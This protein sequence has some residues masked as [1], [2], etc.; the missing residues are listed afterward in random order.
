VRTALVGH[1]GFVGSNLL[2]QATFDDCFNSRTIAEIR[3]RSY[4]LIVCAGLPA[5]KWIANR[6]PESDRAN[7]L[8]LSSH[9]SEVDAEE[10]VLV[11]TVDVYPVPFGVD[12]LTP[13][14][15][16]GHPY[17]AHRLAFEDFVRAQFPRVSV[18]RLPALFGTGLRKNVLYD[19]LNGK[20]LEAVDPSSEFQWYDVCRLWADLQVARSAGLE[21]VNL[22][23][24]PVATGEILDRCFPGVRV[25]GVGL[26]TR[27]DVRTR[28]AAA[29]GRSGPY[30]GSR[31]E[32]L[33]GIAAFVEE[34]ACAA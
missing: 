23:V 29:F 25:G 27:Y 16:A 15:L 10:V 33:D 28:H 13:T 7:V 32:V 12:E 6:E 18:V 14:E 19:L 34:A 11:S 26:Q 4:D 1:T 20:L 31:D 3:G 21:L 17:G 22:A 24:E 2:R 9:L 8:A 30:L 5:A